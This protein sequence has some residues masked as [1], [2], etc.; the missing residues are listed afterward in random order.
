[1]S[2][3]G[4]TLKDLR[5]RRT[6]LTEELHL[7]MMAIKNLETLEERR[8]GVRTVR[9]RRRSSSN[10]PGTGKAV[11]KVLEQETEIALGDEKILELLQERNW[12][13]RSDRPL[14]ALRATLSRLVNVG[15][16]VRGDKPKSYGLPE[17]LQR[18]EGGGYETG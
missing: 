8:S 3:Y 1:M 2:E 9:Q 17:R 5:Q 13:P 15:Q 18:P 16:L 6:E 10:G 12:S 11:L 14:N 4:E 7:L